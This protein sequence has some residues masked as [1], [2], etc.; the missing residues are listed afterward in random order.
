MSQTE[1]ITVREKIGF[2]LGDA[3]ANFIFQTIMLLQLS[4]YANTFGISAAAIAVLFLVG[5]LV[6]AFADPVMGAI[7]DRTE[8]KWGKFRPWILWT[9]VPFGIIGFL[10]FY[11]P[12]M[13]QAG[14]LIWAFVTYILLMLVY[15]ANNIP[16]AA[17]GGVITGDQKQR[18]SI[19]SIRFIFVVLATVAIQGFAIPMVN[20]FGKGD[21]AKGYMI[22]MGIFS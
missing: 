21:S 19:F 15:S 8:T 16:Y 13:E 12:D 4:F 1:K 14:K 5:R 3:A 11:T 2:S 17:L 18:N 9:A 20:H 22:T 10:A 6:G 7:A